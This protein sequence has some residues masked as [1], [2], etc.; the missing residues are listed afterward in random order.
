ME[1]R[2]THQ[3]AKVE[4]ETRE[5]GTEGNIKGYSAVYYREGDSS[6]E[7]PLWDGM[8]ERIMPGAFDR[9]IKE[10]D[11]VRGLFNHDP[12]LILGRT[13]AGTMKMSSD[14][15]GLFY[16]IDAGDTTVARDVKEHIRRGDVTGS[17]FAF[18]V[19][20]ETW[21]T[22]DQMEVREITDVKLYDSGP[23][24]YP[25]YDGTTTSV[26][27]VEDDAAK[28]KES[29]DAIKADQAKEDEEHQAAVRVAKVKARLIEIDLWPQDL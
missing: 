15:T 2:F 11:D 5:D 3:A 20:E 19:T 8:V 4:L 22:E 21:R 28:A 7:Y 25:A 27:S 17:S 23:V 14:K 6:T 18:V 10:N 24:T 16:D 12:S 13:T 29:Y 9:A 26:R 1:R